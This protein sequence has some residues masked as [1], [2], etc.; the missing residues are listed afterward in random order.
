MDNNKSQEFGYIT[1][2]ETQKAINTKTAHG[3]QIIKNYLN[4]IKYGADSKKIVS[5]QMYYKK[6]ASSK[7]TDN[8]QKE[9]LDVIKEKKSGK[10]EV[11]QLG[12][13]IRGV[14]PICSKKV[15]SYQ[16]RIKSL[17]KYYHEKCY[18]CQ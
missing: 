16:E 2:P 4:A 1:D 9:S 10:T 17:G 7:S 12:G 5:T 14:C 11:N 15:L 18:K 3:K 8:N 13:S 6:K